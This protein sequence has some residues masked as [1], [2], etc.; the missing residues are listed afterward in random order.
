MMMIWGTRRGG[1]RDKERKKT[2]RSRGARLGDLKRGRKANKT[3]GR[4]KKR[5]QNVPRRPLYDVRVAQPR[6]DPSVLLFDVHTLDAV[7]LALTCPISALPL[8]AFAGSLEASAHLEATKLFAQSN[9][10]PTSDICHR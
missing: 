10:F 4:K 6:P 1:G 5:K 9:A 7:R 8:G 3:Q 2:S